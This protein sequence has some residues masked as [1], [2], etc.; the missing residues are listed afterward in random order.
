MPEVSRY[1]SVPISRFGSL[2]D[3]FTVFTMPPG[4][5][6]YD[7]DSD[8]DS[9][10]SS[11]ALDTPNQIQTSAQKSR[12][13][14]LSNLDRKLNRKQQRALDETM[15]YIPYLE[16]T[17]NKIL[18]INEKYAKVTSLMER[19]KYC[20]AYKHYNRHVKP[21]LDIWH[22]T[23]RGIIWRE[24]GTQARKLPRF[25][26]KKT[27]PKCPFPPPQFSNISS[28]VL[29]KSQRRKAE[30]SPC[31]QPTKKPRPSPD[32]VIKNEVI[33]I[34]DEDIKDEIEE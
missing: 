30:D 6:D 15:R 17:G 2:T 32:V 25:L 9:D 16:R 1:V 13:K 19:R 4:L 34:S 27:I 14:K 29:L 12:S 26:K 28:D 3:G 5:V 22:V 7:S 23:L 24:K 18:S 8:P 11:K 20:P 31:P 33:V 10:H 21:A